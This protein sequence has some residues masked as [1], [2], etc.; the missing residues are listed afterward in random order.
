MA[1]ALLLAAAVGATCSAG[2]N[3][4][5]GVGPNIQ[6]EPGG[7]SAASVTLTAAAA[8]A[9]SRTYSFVAE[10]VGGA[11]DDQKLYC[12]ATTWDFGDGP[13]MTVTPSCAP[14]AA[15]MKIQRR[16]ETTHTYANAGR[17][18]AVFSY[19]SLSTERAIDVR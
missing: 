1:I 16:F 15:G 3:E 2:L 7:R 4:A 9:D 5:A 17:Y 19:G 8:S 10:I 13:A 18:K 14:W 6:N 12:M 11:D